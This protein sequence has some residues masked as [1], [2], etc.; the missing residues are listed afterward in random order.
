VADGQE[1]E[2][3]KH[4]CASPQRVDEVADVSGGATE[5]RR[6]EEEDGQGV[7]VL[8]S[9]RR[10]KRSSQ[11]SNTIDLTQLNANTENT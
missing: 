3:V 2:R 7:G 5:G 4:G 11:S 10:S 6:A 1:R 9:R 8:G